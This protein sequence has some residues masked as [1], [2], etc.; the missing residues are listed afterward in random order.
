VR[1]I[2]TLLAMRLDTPVRIGIG[3]HEMNNG[4][5]QVE[6]IDFTTLTLK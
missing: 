3:G 6:A 1:I 2:F 4:F 5:K